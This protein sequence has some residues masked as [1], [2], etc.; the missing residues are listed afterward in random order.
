MS[1]EQ[2]FFEH[3]QSGSRRSATRMI[4][5]IQ[6]I[7]AAQSILDVGCGTGE[8]LSVFKTSPGVST[9]KGV[10]G[11]Y[12]SRELL[13]I[14]NSEFFPI[15]LLKP[16][17]LSEKFDLV[18]SLE[19]A[20]HLP[21]S[22]AAAF[23]K[24][25][26]KHSDAIV[27]SA[28]IPG[29]GGVQHINEQYPEFWSSLFAE[30]SYDT[31]DCIRP[32]IANIRDIEW[33]YRQNCLVFAKRDS[34]AWNSLRSKHPIVTGSRLSKIASDFFISQRF[35]RDLVLPFRPFSLVCGLAW[36]EIKYA[37]RNFL[38]PR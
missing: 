35:Y 38:H 34:Q 20:E 7:F 23:V 12:V 21:F 30:C 16:F 5:V 36:K 3:I 25:L 19:V 33:W 9:V 37:A 6:E 8:W 13:A 15:D 4:P 32:K 17:D 24:S 1:Y 22:S 11:N 18:I 27:F 10:D 26:V 31:F 14:D 29:Q 2:T 28:A